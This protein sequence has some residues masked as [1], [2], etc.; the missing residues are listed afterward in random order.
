MKNPAAFPQVERLLE[1]MAQLRDPEAGCPWDL[2]Q[3]FSSIVPYTIEEAYEVAD[4]IEN[5]SMDDVKDE[6]GDLL[7][8]VVFYAQLG[9]EQ[10]HFDFE[11]IAQTVA[12]KLVRRHPHVFEHQTQP[13]IET[14]KH[15]WEQVKQQ[16]RDIKSMRHGEGGEDKSI[17]AN[18]PK[19][20]APLIKANKIQKKCAEVG[21]DWPDVEPVFDKVHEEIEEIQQAL[22]EP[23]SDQAHIEEEVGDL[24][25]AVANL[26]RHLGVDAQTALRKANHKFET[27]FRQVEKHVISHGNTLTASSLE[28][29]E[30]IWQQVKTDQL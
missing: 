25:F 28:R 24:L 18:V 30:A 17:L 19:G 9:M 13:S 11:M 10:K 20:M 8:Q 5:G 6:L 2:K 23:V 1:I 4:A 12:D 14:L 21:F 29:L 26:S 15:N 7:F 27:R 3:D 22:N 16:E